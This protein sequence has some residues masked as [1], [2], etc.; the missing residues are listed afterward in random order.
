MSEVRIE[1]VLLEDIDMGKDLTYKEY[2]IKILDTSERVTRSKVFRMCKVQ[3]NIIQRKRQP[4]KERK[5]SRKIFLSYSLTLLNLG[6]RFSLRG[7]G[8]VTP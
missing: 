8:F 6:T 5:N 1:P 4:G 2:P 3:W 7:V